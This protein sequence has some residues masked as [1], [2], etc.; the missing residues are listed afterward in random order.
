MCQYYHWKIRKTDERMACGILCHRK[1]KGD[2]DRWYFSRWDEDT[3]LCAISPV[4]SD[5]LEEIK[6]EFKEAGIQIL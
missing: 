2:V 1:K 4:V 5:D 6:N 3:T